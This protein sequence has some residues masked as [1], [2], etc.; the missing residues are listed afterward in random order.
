MLRR[1]GPIVLRYL[2]RAYE[3]R[4]SRFVRALRAFADGRMPDAEL[5]EGYISARFGVEHHLTSLFRYALCLNRGGHEYVAALQLDS[6]PLDTDTPYRLDPGVRIL[7]DLHDCA[8]VLDR[9]SRRGR[10]IGAV[11]DL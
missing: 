8:L 10:V 3:G 1:I 9:I 7:T 6:D 2:L 5:V 11:D 4:L